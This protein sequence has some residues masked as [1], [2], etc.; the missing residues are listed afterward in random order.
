MEHRKPKGIFA[1]ILGAGNSS[2]YGSVKQTTE[3]DGAPLVRRAVDLAN[4]VCGNRVV[5]VLG[6]EWRAVRDACSPLD[7][8]IV[9]NEGFS[10]GIGSSIAAGI[11]PIRHTARAAIVLLA[12]Q[13]LI[14][15]AHLG[16]LIR[17]WSGD[18]SEIVATS[19]AD[20]SG[21][22]TLFPAGCFDELTRLSGDSGGKRLF[23]DGR[24]K[25]KTVRFELAAADI[26][27]PEDFRRISRSA[28]S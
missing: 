13:P 1:L 24:F 21:P 26:D 12:D 28:R 17:A 6:H 15:A 19:F 18:T 20:S 2:R 27:T 22:P 25:L 5:L 9:R 7:G 10:D 14:S 3:F 4:A 8:F 16:A 23:Q 11:R